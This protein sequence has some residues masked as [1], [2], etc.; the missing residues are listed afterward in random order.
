MKILITAPSLNTQNNVSGIATV[1]KGIIANNISHQ[2]YHY[3]LGRPD[4]ARNKFLLFFLIFK[5]LFLFPIILKFKS[6]ELVHQ[7][8]PFNL[9]GLLREFYINFCC[10]LFKVPVVLHVHGGE[11]LMNGISN[12]FFRKLA[13]I[14]LSKSDIVLVL[15]ELERQALVRNFNFHS[16]EVLANCVDLSLCN[17][18]S[19]K[20]LLGMPTFLF[21]GR[22]HESKGVEDIVK[23]LKLLKK[24]IDFRFIL[25]GDGPLKDFLLKECKSFLGDSFEY[26][27]VV[28]SSLKFEVFKEADVFLLPS[29]YGEGLPMALL[30]TM[31]VGLVPVV[32]GDASMKIVVK[33][34]Y[35]G[36][37]VLK[38]NPQDICAKLLTLVSDRVLYFELSQNAHMTVLQEYNMLSY[39]KTLDNIYLR[40]NKAAL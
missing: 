23:A 12:K 32:T 40:L 25:C 14:L 28:A 18:H 37:V 38:N 13:E 10:R 16:A 24:K 8:L 33:H 30:E 34:A 20:E 3:K 27:G 36:F 19:S 26:K 6:I 5:Q 15:S 31:A 11:F 2:Y 17:N 7:N 29:R 22:I 1:V 4:H 35:N 39:T 9:K 21:F